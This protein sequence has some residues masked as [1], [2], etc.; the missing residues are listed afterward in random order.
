M[1]D[2]LN[3]SDCDTFADCYD[4]WT[5][6]VGAP[7]YDI[8]FYKEVLLTCPLGFTVE[9][10]AGVGRVADEIAFEDRP[11]V[12][13]DE[14][15][16]MLDRARQRAQD[17]GLAELIEWI[18]AGFGE[19]RTEKPVAAV[20]C[21]CHTLNHLL[22]DDDWLTVFRNVSEYLQPRGAFAFNNLDVS[23]AELQDLTGIIEPI[24]SI[25]LGES[26]AIVHKKTIYENSTRTWPTM[27]TGEIFSPDGESEFATDWTLSKA[28]VAVT[29]SAALL[30]R[31]V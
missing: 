10:G 26:T 16:A 9:L 8:E 7:K 5:S 27:V 1:G 31:W 17:R 2:Y 15:Q 12:G 19:W 21:P 28:G 18:Q 14:S 6:L 11:V 3:E 30:A 24:G 29:R 22:T 4:L 13:I 23:L 20:I 25:S